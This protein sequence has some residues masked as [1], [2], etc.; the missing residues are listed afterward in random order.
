MIALSQTRADRDLAR[1]NFVGTT[2]GSTLAGGTTVRA[3]TR[4]VAR[5]HEKI[6]ATLFRTHPSEPHV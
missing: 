3:I 5:Q 6:A 4:D 2:L 1:T